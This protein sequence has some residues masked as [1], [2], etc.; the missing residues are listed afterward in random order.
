MGLVEDY[1]ARMVGCLKEKRNYD[2]VTVSLL[3]R[4][5]CSQRGYHCCY[6]SRFRSERI[7]CGDSSSTQYRRA[8]AHYVQ[9]RRPITVV[10]GQVRQA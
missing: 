1:Q 2:R 6:G 4:C 3:H 7:R 9:T 8:R 5:V 10:V